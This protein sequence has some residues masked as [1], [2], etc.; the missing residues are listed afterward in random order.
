LSLV[1]LHELEAVLLAGAVA[2]GFPTELWT[3]ARIATVIRRTFHQRYHPSGVWWVLQR[4]GWSCQKPERRATQRD[5]AQI[6]RW[7]R[8]RWPQLKKVPAAGH[9]AGFPGRKR[10]RVGAQRQACFQYH[11]RDPVAD[12]NNTLKESHLSKV[13]M[14]ATR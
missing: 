9:Y 7:R 10:L 14:R 1:E 13:E 5:E 6:A 4:M 12:E 2:S 11:K 8:Y 3:L